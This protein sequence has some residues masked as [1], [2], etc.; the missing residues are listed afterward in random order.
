MKMN[1]NIVNY[2]TYKHADF[3]LKILCIIRYIK[4]TKSNYFTD[5]KIYTQIHT[6]FLCSLEYKYV[7]EINILHVCVI[8]HWLYVDFFQKL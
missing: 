4:M 7:F 8:N 5:L 3:Q 2:V 1:S 6:S